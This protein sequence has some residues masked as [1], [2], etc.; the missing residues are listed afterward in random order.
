MNRRGIT[1]L[2]TWLLLALTLVALHSPLPV[3][4]QSCD[5]I[6]NNADATNCVGVAGS[7]DLNSLIGNVGPRFVVWRA[8]DIR[9]V[10][11]GPFSDVLLG[12]MGQVEDRFVIR[13]ANANKLYA[14][15]Y[16][17]GLANDTTPPQISELI[18]ET[19]G[20]DRVKISWL[21]NEFASTV[22]QYGT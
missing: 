11:V 7:A 21:T 15:A 6:V 19:I 3:R 8:N 13:Y 10:R 17:K 16:P 2:K 9:Y 22:L 20:T 18:V 14:T 5:I 1:L 4:G 12:L